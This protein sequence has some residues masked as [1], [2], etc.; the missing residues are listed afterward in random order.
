MKPLLFIATMA[1]APIAAFEVYLMNPLDIYEG[2]PGRKEARK[3]VLETLGLEK[4]ASIGKVRA[5]SSTVLAVDVKEGG[6]YW[7]PITYR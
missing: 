4:Q 2:A 3:L 6:D 5:K 1:S 7:F